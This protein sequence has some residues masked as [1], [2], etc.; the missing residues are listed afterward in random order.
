MTLFYTTANNKEMQTV[1][2]AM[3][4]DYSKVNDNKLYY[5]TKN[6]NGKE[7]HVIEDIDWL[8]VENI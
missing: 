6:D 7:L 4:I 8:S 3:T 5:F 1:E 2:N